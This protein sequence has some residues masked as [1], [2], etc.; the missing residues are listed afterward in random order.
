MPEERHS[1]QPPRRRRGT[2]QNRRRHQSPRRDKKIT[3]SLS[4]Q[5]YAALRDAASRSHLAVGAFVAHAALAE[6][7]GTRRPDQ[8]ELRMLLEELM[9]VGGQVR[10]LGVNLNQAVAALHS[11]ELTQQLGAYAH[12]CARAVVK[13]DRTADEI[14][15]RLP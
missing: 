1:K 14:C 9:H 2:N 13:L 11:G 6:A 7:N 8:A 10:R 15:R 12:A 4:Q 5:E 3:F